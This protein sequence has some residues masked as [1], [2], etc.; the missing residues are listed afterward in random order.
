M[1]TNFE[2]LQQLQRDGIREK[3]AVLDEAASGVGTRVSDESMRL[4][5]QIFLMQ[6]QSAPRTVV[7][8]GIEHGDGCSH[9]CASVAETLANLG[10]RVCL[11]EANLRSPALPQLLGTANH[12]GL[13]DALL[14]RG[15]IGSYTKAVGIDNLWLLSCGDLSA[16]SWNLLGSESIKPRL[17]ELR[18]QFD[19]LIIDAPPLSRYADALQLGRLTDGV[20]LILEANATR[21]DAAQKV[22][23]S[24][25]SHSIPILGAVLNKRT[26]PIPEKIYNWL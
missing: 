18:G 8:A 25:R 14:H 11:V 7:F 15:P 10:K 16:D 4:V 22:T 13:T 12:P 19:F 2:V 20:V 6:G 1:S 23:A 5:Q 26:F 3:S 24:L 9:V 21:R 17:D